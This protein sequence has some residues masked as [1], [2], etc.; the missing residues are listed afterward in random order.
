VLCTNVVV[1][2]SSIAV[3]MRLN[4]MPFEVIIES[5]AK[6]KSQESALGIAFDDSVMS[7]AKDAAADACLGKKEFVL[8]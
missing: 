4:F 8:A 6:P 7:P 2:C 1:A 3:K 5:S